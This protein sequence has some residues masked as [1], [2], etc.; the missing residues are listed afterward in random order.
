MVEPR[1][2]YLPPS[3]E[4]KEK[5]QESDVEAPSWMK[6]RYT[7]WSLKIHK[8]MLLMWWKS[9]EEATLAFES[10]K[11]LQSSGV[12][13]QKTQNKY[14]PWFQPQNYCEKFG[15]SSLPI[16]LQPQWQDKDQRTKEETWGLKR[17]F[18]V[19]LMMSR[20]CK[21]KAKSLL[22][23][24][25]TPLED[26]LR[27]PESWALTLTWYFEI[28]IFINKIPQVIWVCSNVWGPLD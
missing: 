27:V 12:S 18:I 6:L 17:G 26:L 13:G 2:L 3:S 9:W 10:T 14:T 28:C 25:S 16:C 15:F 5:Q 20:D 8:E 22:L 1:C 24:L 23:W 19:W 21:V 7:I 4:T 11:L